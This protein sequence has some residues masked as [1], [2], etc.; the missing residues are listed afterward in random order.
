MASVADPHSVTA[1]TFTATERASRAV[2]ASHSANG[3]RAQRGRDSGV[4]AP[5]RFLRLPRDQPRVERPDEAVVAGDHGCCILRD[6]QYVVARHDQAFT[7]ER[8]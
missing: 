1:T 2:T 4:T 5:C 8:V 6:P 7:W 3:T